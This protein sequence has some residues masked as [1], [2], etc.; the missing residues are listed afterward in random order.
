MV[1]GRLQRA[2]KRYPGQ[3][4][5]DAEGNPTD[6]PAVMFSEP[7]GAMLPLGG[8]EAGHKGFALGLLVEAL[9]GGLPGHARADPQEGWVG[10]VF[11]EVFD[12]GAFAGLHEFIRQMAFLSNAV[13]AT[14]PRPGFDRVRLPGERGLQLRREQLATGV[15]LHDGIVPQLTP[16]AEKLGVPLP[17]PVAGQ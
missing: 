14:P 5:M 10:N 17:P 9:S 15:R 12:P 2:G 1:T 16:W 11:L 13:H 4:V 3:W 7:R 6:D 8:V